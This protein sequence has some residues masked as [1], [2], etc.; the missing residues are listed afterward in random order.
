MLDNRYGGEGPPDDRRGMDP[1][2][3][4]MDSP[5]GESRPYPGDDRYGDDSFQGQ[6]ESFHGQP[7]SYHD[8]PDSYQ[9][10]PNYSGSHQMLDRYTIIFTTAKKSEVLMFT[11]FRYLFIS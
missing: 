1:R 6:P 2:D 9:D 8:Q 4:Y 11:P 3:N 10:H 5:R 7:A